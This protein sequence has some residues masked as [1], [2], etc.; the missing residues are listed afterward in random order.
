M[1]LLISS[2]P[3]KASRTLV[4]SARLAERFN[5]RSGKFDIKRLE[6][7][8]F[9]SLPSQTSENDVMI[10]FCVD[11]ASLATSLKSA[12]PSRQIKAHAVR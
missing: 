4:D 1:C 2:L 5:M 10:Y 7:I 3:D 8:L 11:P 12:T 9:I 6:S